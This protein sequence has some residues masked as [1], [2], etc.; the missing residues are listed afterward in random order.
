MQC[1]GNP[2]ASDTADFDRQGHDELCQLCT[3]EA[4][5]STDAS[6]RSWAGN[7]V[8]F[9]IGTR[10]NHNDSALFKL[11][12]DLDIA[13]ISSYCFSIINCRF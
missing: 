8:T 10:K 9:I 2:K 1:G 5:L 4:G 11:T 7:Q 12:A 3:S 6:D 13:A